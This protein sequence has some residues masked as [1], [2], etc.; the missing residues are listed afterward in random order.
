MSEKRRKRRESHN[1]VERRRRDNINEKITELATLIPEVMLDPIAA[2]SSGGKSTRSF[3]PSRSMLINVFVRS[4]GNGQDDGAKQDDGSDGIAPPPSGGSSN[5]KEPK[6]N[7]GGVKANKGMILRKS[8]DYI[9][10]LQQLVS[11][12]AARN[13]TLE[14]TL[15]R[16]GLSAAGD[17][18]DSAA[19][20]LNGSGNGFKLGAFGGAFLEPMAE[21][22]AEMEMD[23]EMD[24]EAMDMNIQ[25]LN[26]R[27]KSQRLRDSPGASGSD[28]HERDRDNE[29]QDHEDDDADGRS[30][31]SGSASGSEPARARGRAGSD[32]SILAERGRRGRDAVVN[33]M[34][35]G[36][37]D[38]GLVA[39]KEE[40]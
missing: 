37:E 25:Y 6:E 9:R 36:G 2:T 3:R 38:N 15:A 32:V 29:H 31:V 40:A 24:A 12:Q 17:D 33:G 19:S 7:N 34:V 11:A 26:G 18:P 10:Y 23:L 4:S 5:G 1:A 28:D 16:A 8:V 21:G 39:V 13:R 22:D 35:R 20:S 30:S 14:A 27:A